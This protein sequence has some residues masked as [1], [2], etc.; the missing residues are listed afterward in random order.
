MKL[1]SYVANGKPSFGVVAGDGVVTMNDRLG[2][3]FATLRDAIAGGAI[4]EMRRATQ[5]A[6]PD[7]PLAGLQFLPTIPNPE[8]IMCVG[9]NYKSHAAEHGTEA[10]KHPNI[11][12]LFINTLVSQGGDMTRPK[13][14][15][16]FDFEG[17]LALVIGKAGRH[18]KAADA[19]G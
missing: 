16:N 10:P 17:K 6:K 4:D 12:L 8:K 13:V 1:A 9:I 14:S 3:R 15:T 18:I 19:L 5:G 2:N 11:F 7:H